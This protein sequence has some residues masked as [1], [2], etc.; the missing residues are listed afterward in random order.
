MLLAVSA[1]KMKQREQGMN[2]KE[3][4]LRL[5]KKNGER[6]SGDIDVR[7]NSHSPVGS[8]SNPSRNRREAR[9]EKWDI[10]RE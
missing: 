6:I 1:A 2:L 9:E 10:D 7:L 4:W 5:G 8:R 3:R